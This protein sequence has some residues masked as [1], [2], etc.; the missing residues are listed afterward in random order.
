M[1]GQPYEIIPASSQIL[2][3]IPAP[4]TEFKRLNLNLINFMADLPDLTKENEAVLKIVVNSRDPTSPAEPPRDATFVSEFQAVDGR[5]APSFLSR[6]VFRNVLFREWIRLRFQLNEI[7]SNM[8][9]QY[10]ALKAAINSVPEV[11]HVDVLKGAPYLMLASGLFDAMLETFAKSGDDHLWD[12]SPTLEI[13]PT[14]GGAFLRTGIYVLRS[15]VDPKEEPVEWS[16]LEYVD[17]ILKRK[18][19]GAPPNHLIF[20]VLVRGYDG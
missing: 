11:R 15:A 1:A 14:P 18:G 13:C 20:G 7:D 12:E 6:G 3:A 4:T 9:E 17:E 19:G 5:Y 10:Q 2:E 8:L 16:A